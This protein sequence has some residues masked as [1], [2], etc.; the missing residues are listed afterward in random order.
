MYIHISE[1]KQIVFSNRLQRD[2]LRNLCGVPSRVIDDAEGRKEGPGAPCPYCG[3]RDRFKVRNLD[4]DVQLFCRNSDCLGGWV[5]LID[6][7]KKA[8][9]LTAGQAAR[10][11]EGYLTERGYIE[12]TRNRYM[13]GY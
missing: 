4:G 8:R 12:T 10:K 13:R 3:G 7:I 5:D 1:L 2:V 6:G 11:L 9:N